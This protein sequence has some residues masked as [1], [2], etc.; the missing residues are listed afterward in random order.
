MN[1]VIFP[2]AAA[3][4]YFAINRYLLGKE[5]RGMK[6]V[7][8]AI[9]VLLVAV[10]F[11]H[12]SRYFPGREPYSYLSGNILERLLPAYPKILR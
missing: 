8:T 2:I 12:M 1:P 7:I 6:W 5:A 10:Y 4:L 3:G 11:G 9:A